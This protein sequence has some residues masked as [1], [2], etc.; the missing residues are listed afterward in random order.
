MF[1][2]LKNRRVLVNLDTGEQLVGIVSRTGPLYARIT[3]ASAV[4]AAGVSTDIG[5]PVRIRISR[6]VTLQEL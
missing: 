3:D 6:V 1:T 2:G 4:S 5:S